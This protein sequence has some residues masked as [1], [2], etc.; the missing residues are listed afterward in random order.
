M[1]EAVQREEAS[2]GVPYGGRDPTVDRASNVLEELGEGDGWESSETNGGVGVEGVG[3]PSV[4]DVANGDAIRESRD[5]VRREGERV[6]V[7][8]DDWSMSGCRDDGKQ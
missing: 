2:A 8:E 7:V 4:G 5:G 1:A 6:R 3:E